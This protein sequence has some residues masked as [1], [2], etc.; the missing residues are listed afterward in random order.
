VCFTGVEIAGELTI[1]VD[2]LKGKQG[3][4]PV[5]ELADRWVVHGVAGADFMEALDRAC[6]EAQRFLVDQW[7]FSM[8]EAFI[9]MSVACDANICQACRPQDFSTIARVAIPKVSASPR[10]FS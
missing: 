9:F 10:P 1:R 7:G 4:Y 6:E 2:L 8:E 5:T 3:T